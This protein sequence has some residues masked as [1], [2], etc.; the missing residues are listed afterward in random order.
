MFALFLTGCFNAELHTSARR[1]VLERL[2]S[3]VSSDPAAFRMLWPLQD[4]E[5]VAER[6]HHY[7]LNIRHRGCF[8]ALA[9]SY[10]AFLTTLSRVSSW[11]E[12]QELPEK[13][14]KKRLSA[15][16]DD[17][18]S[19]TRRSAGLPYLILATLVASRSKRSQLLQLSMDHLF[20]VAQDNTTESNN[21]VQVHS[22]NTL[23][24][25]FL[26]SK[27]GPAVLPYAE[28]GFL[29]SIHS[30][31]SEFWP[32]R[33]AALLLYSALIQRVFSSSSKKSTSESSAWAGRP[34]RNDFFKE[35]PIE[36]A[37]LQELDHCLQKTGVD[38]TEGDKQ[39]SLFA[40]LL[41]L[42]KLATPTRLPGQTFANDPLLLRVQKCLGSRVWK[43]GTV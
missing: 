16:V 4:I 3:L 40:V 36:N 26:E 34:S 11:P 35:Y 8:T 43:V 7:L 27:L 20:Q 42:S 30:F 18:L 6:Y 13:W 2:V 37:L 19:F 25:I 29:L 22:I 28:R 24:S 31:R 38:A 21:N 23:R 15:S 1:I 41:L 17:T 39:S 10:E 33:N 32:T 12:L 5:K 14:L 9:D